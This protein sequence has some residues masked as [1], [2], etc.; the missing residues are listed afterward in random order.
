MRG[1]IALISRVLAAPASADPPDISARRLL[2]GWR[3]QDRSTSMLVEVIASAF[4]GG[5]SRRGSLA[6]KEVY[7]PLPDFKGRQVMI[8]FEKVP[9]GPP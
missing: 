6:G 7:C 3:D 1:A 4:A 2:A 8:A 5:L 9:R